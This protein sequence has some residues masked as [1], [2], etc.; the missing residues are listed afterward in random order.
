MLQKNISK[1][2][3]PRINKN[4]N[5]S[6]EG[7]VEIIQWVGRWVRIFCIRSRHTC[8]YKSYALACVLRQKGVPVS[9]NLGLRN[10]GSLEKNRGHCWLTFKGKPVLESDDESHRLYPHLMQL[11]KSD[12]NYWVGA[13]DEQIIQRHKIK[14]RRNEAYH[15]TKL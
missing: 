2:S 5:L 11:G 3:L 14:K 6:S 15:N 13:N 10:L 7:L 12:V 4:N 8:Y 9:L 1:L